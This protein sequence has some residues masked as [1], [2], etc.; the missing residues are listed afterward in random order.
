MAQVSGEAPLEFETE[1]ELAAHVVLMA[2]E[3]VEAQS[4]GQI[5]AGAPT[6]LMG[7]ALLSDEEIEFLVQ[8]DAVVGGTAALV[9]VYIGPGELQFSQT[10]PPPECE[11]V[12]SPTF[13]DWPE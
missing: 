11:L 13:L 1:D 5:D 9:S 10:T 6:D 8:F 3:L 4:T 12:G 2:E 7:C